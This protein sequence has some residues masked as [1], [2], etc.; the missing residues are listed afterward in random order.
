MQ[1]DENVNTNTYTWLEAIDYC[2]GK[3]NGWRSP[4]IQELSFLSEYGNSNSINSIFQQASTNIYWSVSESVNSNN[5]GA[6]AIGFDGGVLSR[7]KTLDNDYIR[8]VN[9]EID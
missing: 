9:N 5:E 7:N 8:C 2:K 1:D 6:W 3:G 4:T